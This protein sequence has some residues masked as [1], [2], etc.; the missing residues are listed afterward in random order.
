MKI[1]SFI[2]PDIKQAL[3]QIRKEIG[4]SA[5]ILETRECAGNGFK[6]LL[7]KGLIEVI[8]A[9]SNDLRE[10]PPG[11]FTEG[12][13][14]DITVHNAK[15][16]DTDQPE[17]A[18]P[19]AVGIISNDLHPEIKRLKAEMMNQE[20]QEEIVN[21]LLRY[22][23]AAS[24]GEAE[25][26]DIKNIMAS[27]HERIAGMVKIKRFAGLWLQKVDKGYKT[28]LPL[29]LDRQSTIGRVV[30]FVGPTGVGKTT[31]LAKVAARLVLEMGKSVGVITI[32]TYRIA[33]VDQLRA[34]AEMMDIP[35]IVAFTPKELSMA[36]ERFKDKEYVLIDT[37]GRSQYDDKRIRILGGLLKALPS[38][39]NY[40]VI[41]AGTR[42]REASDIFTSFNIL[43]LHGCI[44]TKID[45][46]GAFGMLLNMAVKTELPICFLTNGQEVPDD[47]EDASPERIA[48][49]ILPSV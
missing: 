18:V 39:E 33:A 7:G 19:G 5:L 44:F 43:P 34:F 12:L 8:A 45:E 35:I 21:H 4:A 26:V 29:I 31:T 13:D 22:E 41:S 40:L 3:N 2:A 46:A 27:V 42:N 1:K 47:I 37:A 10:E 24:G 20:V 38:S 32:D 6:G 36:V 30:T 14:D 15:W 28:P 16:Q 23:M 25:D 49:L 11:D 9:Y 17:D 48:E